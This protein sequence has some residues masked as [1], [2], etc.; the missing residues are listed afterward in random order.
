MGAIVYHCVKG[1]C[2]E[3]TAIAKSLYDDDYALWLAETVQQLRAQDFKNLDLEHLID[4][5]ESLG[6]RDQQAIA[7][8]LMR[9]CEHLLKVR[10]WET[11]RDRCLRG[12]LVEI[13][14][15]R[16]QIE[17]CLEDS[18]SLKRFLAANFQKQYQNGRKLF[19]KASDLPA[20][21]IPLEP[22]FSL[23]QCLDENWLPTD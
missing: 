14:N 19:L 18:P 15:F 4:E 13:A 11:E 23:E 5:V 3:T 2:M 22:E 10:Y 21:Q 17:M 6:K 8:Y 12:W 7:S 20:A 1:F 9:L 16:I